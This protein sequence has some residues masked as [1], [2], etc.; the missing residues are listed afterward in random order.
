MRPAIP[1]RPPAEV[2][3]DFAAAQAAKSDL[4][5]KATEAKSR[6]ETV[7]IAAKAKARS[8]EN[9][10]R[11]GSARSIDL[12]QARASRFLALLSESERSRRLT[13]R[14]LYLDAVR[15]LLPKVRRK[16]LLTPQESVDLSVFGVDK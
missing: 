2:Q 13:I 10:A 15:D 5:R 11:A 7:L 14:R 4:D 12:A 16:I 6:A 3:P 8:I 1:A 9:S